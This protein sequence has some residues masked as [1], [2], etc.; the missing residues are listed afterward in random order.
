MATILLSGILIA[1][2]YFI[3]YG[4]TW[5]YLD[6]GSNQGTTW[7]NTSFNDASW[8][9]GPAQLGYGDGDEATV[10]SY[11]SNANKKFI[12]TYFR[13]TITIADASTFSSFILNVKRDDGAVVFIN[14][15]ERFRTNM[16]NGTISYTTKASTDAADDEIG[17][18]HV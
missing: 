4:S 3:N 6:N 17:R 11:G 15:T 7:R 18:A 8:A 9:S 16:P 10:V 12:T 5:K 1:Q 13:K 2:T 14:G